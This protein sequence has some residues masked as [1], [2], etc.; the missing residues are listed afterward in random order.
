ME[1]TKDT[2]KLAGHVTAGQ[3]MIDGS[4]V[5]DVGSVIL[6][7]RRLLAEDGLIEVKSRGG[8]KHMQTAIGRSVSGSQKA[9]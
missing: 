9:T 4:T 8:K 6:R 3:I 7:D 5:G 2:G 1:F